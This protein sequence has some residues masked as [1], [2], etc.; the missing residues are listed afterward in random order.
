MVQTFQHLEHLTRFV[1]VVVAVALLSS[2]SRRREMWILGPLAVVVGVVAKQ[3]ALPG[4]VLVGDV[5]WAGRVLR[6][7]ATH[8]FTMTIA[9]ITALG[10]APESVAILCGY[11]GNG[12][13]FF[14]PFMLPLVAVVACPI[15]FVGLAVAGGVALRRRRVARAG[16]R[17]AAALG[18]GGVA[19]GTFVLGGC[20]SVVLG[21]GPLLLFVAAGPRIRWSTLLWGLAGA[22]ASSFV[23]A[24]RYE[25]AVF[26][27]APAIV[28]AGATAAVT[29]LHR[30]V[31]ARRRRV[32]VGQW[33][34]R[35]IC[36]RGSSGA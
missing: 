17:W 32:E 2:V 35:R 23:V 4:A 15:A 36:R 31:M 6:G 12:S 13:T 30:S 22:F 10:T 33:P 7:A 19:V 26:V 28:I 11:G 34:G 29:A 27:V 18:F 24:W 9:V 14:V 16:H 3:Q 5:W 20:S 25:S 8:R 1:V 21:T